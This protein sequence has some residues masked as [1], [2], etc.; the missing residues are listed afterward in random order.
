MI[1]AHIGERV[2]VELPYS[3]VCMHM[4]VA[5]KRMDVEV[6]PD[7]A[8]L[9]NADGSKFSFPIT[10]GEAGIRAM[11]RHDPECTACEHGCPWKGRPMGAP[12]CTVCDDHWEAAA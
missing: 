6:L 7:G 11:E 3:E 5:G 2:T 8:Q 1:H 4:R 10:H 12:F 9:L